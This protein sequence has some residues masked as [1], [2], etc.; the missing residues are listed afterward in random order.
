MPTTTR[1]PIP[2]QVGWMHD[3]GDGTATIV[4]AVDQ[5]GVGVGVD[6]P[7]NGF[8]ITSTQVVNAVGFNSNG[9]LSVYG[10][11]DNLYNADGSAYDASQSITVNG[12]TGSS[13]FIGPQTISSPDWQYVETK[14]TANYNVQG[15]YSRADVCAASAVLH[16]G[17]A[18]GLDAVGI[19]PGEGTSGC[20]CCFRKYGRFRPR[21]QSGEQGCCPFRN[22]SRSHGS[23]H[24]EGV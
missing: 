5:N 13:S 18:T 14:S 24:C 6:C 17:P 19:I 21:L 4:N 7:G 10:A 11:G 9:D 22:W 23:R 2:I 1:W 16:K 8:Y 20:R 3:N 12:D 15:G